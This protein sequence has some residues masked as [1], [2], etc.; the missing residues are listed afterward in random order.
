MLKIL[1]TISVVSLVYNSYSITRKRESLTTSIKSLTK[2]QSCNPGSYYNAITNECTLC[3]SGSYSTTTD[4]TSCL[5]CHHGFITQTRGLT[6]CTQCPI[7]SYSYKIVDPDE[8]VDE[9]TPTPTLDPNADP[10]APVPKRRHRPG[11]NAC[12]VC[13][14]GYYANGPT[15]SC[16]ICPSISGTST[17]AIVNNNGQDQSNNDY[18]KPTER[19]HSERSSS[20]TSCADVCELGSFFN[21]KTQACEKCQPGFIAS[22]TFNL[23]CTACSIG[24]YS[25]DEGGSV[26]TKCEPGTYSISEKKYGYTGCMPCPAGK[27][28]PNGAS[29]LDCTDNKWS[30]PNS[31]ECTE[32]AKS[33]LEISLAT[34][35]SLLQVSMSVKSVDSGA[36]TC[37]AGQYYDE[38]SKTCISC[39]AGSFSAAG[40]NYCILCPVGSYQNLAGQACCKTCSTILTEGSTSG[41]GCESNSC[42]VY[43]EFESP[44]P[45]S[46]SANGVTTVVPTASNSDVSTGVPTVA[47]TATTT[48]APTSIK[49]CAAGQYYSATTHSCQDCGAGSYSLDNALSCTLCPVGTFQDEAGKGCCKVCEGIESVG[50]L[51]GRGCDDAVCVVPE[52]ITVVTSAPGTS[53]SSSV[54]TLSSISCDAGYEGIK[55]EC[56]ACKAGYFK[57]STGFEY[58]TACNPGQFQVVEAQTF[59]YECVAGRYSSSTSVSTCENCVPGH[60]SPS[61]SSTVC[62]E[63]ELGDYQAMEGNDNC[64]ACVSGTYSL[65]AQ[66]ACA[67]CEAG[68]YSDASTDGQSSCTL[69]GV[70]TWNSWNAADSCIDCD[71]GQYTLGK[72]STECL[73]CPSGVSN[74]ERSACL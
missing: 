60:Y 32:E 63:C 56:T 40:S 26:C 10:N 30:S 6:A 66:S 43:N 4:A 48:N 17:V 62:L 21:R 16:S 41:A 69:C 61:Q 39:P 42:V 51:F 15:T 31:A 27:Y 2:T 18:K 33:L 1:K 34:T 47:P 73:D 57:A 12:Q 19:I 5:K 13:E 24:T 54:K 74:P 25:K 14:K 49:V 38:C 3:N 8:P 65:W 45:T 53:T 67:E 46:A 9:P 72:G 28:S 44:V 70:G 11:H 71:E 50:S 58:C 22:T 52:S 35:R 7:G 37:V 29:C 20:S 59:C 55:G 68:S 23:R 36:N 64:V